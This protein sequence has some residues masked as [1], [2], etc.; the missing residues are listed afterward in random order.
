MQLR[1]SDAVFR[2]VIMTWTNLVVLL[3]IL[4]CPVSM[5]WMM[6]KRGH[7]HAGK[8]TAVP[9]DLDR[10]DVTGGRTHRPSPE[11]LTGFVP[12]TGLGA[13]DAATPASKISSGA[14]AIGSSAIK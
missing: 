4:A 11:P 14:E 7:D 3:V 1:H 5:M 8:N 12:R 13:P 10:I 6:R 9:R 2:E